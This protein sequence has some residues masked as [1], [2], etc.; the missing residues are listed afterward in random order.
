MKNKNSNV[1]PDQKTAILTPEGVNVADRVKNGKTAL[2]FTPEV[3]KKHADQIRSYVYPA[4][5]KDRNF[6]GY[7]VPK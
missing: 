7:C 6:I 2:F 1:L 5:D 4:F 3:A